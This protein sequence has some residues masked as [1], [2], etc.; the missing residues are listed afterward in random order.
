MAPVV[1]VALDPRV[2]GDPEVSPGAVPVAGGVP[3]APVALDEVATMV[4]NRNDDPLVTGRI[5]AVTVTK[6]IGAIRLESVVTTAGVMMTV[7]GIAPIGPVV[8]R[9][10]QTVVSFPVGSMTNSRG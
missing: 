7:E 9:G 5:D 10:R 4:P 3:I 8:P 6:T 2:E 1:L